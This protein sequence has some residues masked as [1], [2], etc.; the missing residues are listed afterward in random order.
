MSG[1]ILSEGGF[2]PL[3]QKGEILSGQCWVGGKGSTFKVTKITLARQNNIL[4]YYEY[5]LPY[6]SETCT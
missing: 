1:G 2:C 3:V 6:L 4:P 5:L